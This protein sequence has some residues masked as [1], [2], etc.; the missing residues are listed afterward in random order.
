MLSHATTTW[1][2]TMGF[3]DERGATTSL[4]RAGM[5][6]I[7]NEIFGSAPPTRTIIG[8]RSLHIHP[9]IQRQVSK[10]SLVLYL[11]RDHKRES[12]II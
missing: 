9:T 11:Q 5:T 1:F 3:Q 4:Q 6:A 8:R 2:L 7:G 10:I 12:N